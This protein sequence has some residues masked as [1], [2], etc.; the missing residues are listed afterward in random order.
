MNSIT[1]PAGQ[2]D[3]P[4]RED[5]VTAIDTLNAS[6]RYDPKE[7]WLP[8]YTLLARVRR[9]LRCARQPYDRARFLLTVA[10]M[11]GWAYGFWRVMSQPTLSFWW[12]MALMAA[13]GLASAAL[14]AALN[15]FA[16]RRHPLLRLQRDIEEACR[17]FDEVVQVVDPEAAAT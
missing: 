3:Q 4:S 7:Q 16:Q 12:L 13:T 11:S 5:I 2:P 1:T 8:S 15:T 6:F 9:E 14:G 10:L 17:F